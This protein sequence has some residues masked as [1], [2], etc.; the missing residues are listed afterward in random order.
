M[1]GKVTMS[2]TICLTQN[3][4][5][6]CSQKQSNVQML[7]SPCRGRWPRITNSL[8]VEP[9]ILLTTEFTRKRSQ[10]TANSSRNQ[11]RSCLRVTSTF[12]ALTR[13]WHL[14]KRCNVTVN[15]LVQPLS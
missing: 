1:I 7:A 11:E 12:F 3:V 9:G 5:N 4:G 8:S 10:Q 6:D 15:V 14:L 13:C 2:H